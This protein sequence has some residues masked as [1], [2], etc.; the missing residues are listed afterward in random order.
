MKS[1]QSFRKFNDKLNF[2][3]FSLKDFLGGMECTL[4]EIVGASGNRINRPL[5]YLIWMF[6]NQNGAFVPE[7]IQ[8]GT[9]LENFGR[10][11]P[12]GYFAQ[13]YHTKLALRGLSV[14]VLMASAGNSDALPPPPGNGLM[15][16]EQTCWQCM[17]NLA[18]ESKIQ[19][20]MTPWNL[21]KHPTWCHT[22]MPL[23]CSDVQQHYCFRRQELRKTLCVSF[24]DKNYNCGT[25]T[26]R[27]D[28]V[29]SCKVSIQVDSPNDKH[30]LSAWKHSN[31]G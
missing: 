8:S 14:F 7:N 31:I 10:T 29:S 17:L 30:R 2:L 9:N 24:R 6:W 15:C 16:F 28:E 1:F 12:F 21:C 4:G 11:V 13:K 23:M 18:R 3:S 25:I 22:A 5:R 20:I 26:V 27:A 19:A